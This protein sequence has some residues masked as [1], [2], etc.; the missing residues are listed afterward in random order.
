ME[1]N[2]QEDAAKVLA[3]A[4]QAFKTSDAPILALETKS[5]AEIAPEGAEK[6]I[7][8]EL[9]RLRKE[10]NESCP[11]FSIK[12]NAAGNP[13]NKDLLK[14]ALEFY[15]KCRISGLE[16][17][18][19]I[20]L[21]RFFGLYSSYVALVS[22][23]GES[24]STIDFE[25]LAVALSSYIQLEPDTGVKLKCFVE[26]GHLPNPADDTP[27]KWIG[28]NKVDAGAFWKHLGKKRKDW[29]AAFTQPWGK[30]IQ[31]GDAQYILSDNP[32]SLILESFGIENRNGVKKNR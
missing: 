12:W 30:P 11:L 23:Q 13:D 10:I 8:Q 7:K 32:V 24:E 15:E 25:K 16:D 28:E 14:C 18:G 19:K 20:E 21:E 29:Q 27:M 31:N 9:F 26:K 2:K 3:I 1:E 22:I 4:Q 17:L 5:L 6:H